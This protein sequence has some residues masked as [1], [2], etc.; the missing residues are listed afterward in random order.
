MRWPSK[1]YPSQ[2]HYVQPSACRRSDLKLRVAY[3]IIQSYGIK[4][5]FVSALTFP[6]SH[7]LRFFFLSK[8]AYCDNPITMDPREAR[9]TGY[10]TFSSTLEI[11]P[12]T[13]GPPRLDPYHKILSRFYEPLVLLRL[14]GQSRGNHQPK[15]HDVNA[16]QAVR[17]DFLRNLSYICDFEKGGDTCTA[18][19]LA[20]LGAC[21]RLYVA[22][23]KGQAKIAEFLKDVLGLLRDLNEVPGSELPQKEAEFVKFCV[24]FAERRIRKEKSHLFRAADACSR[25]L[26]H[27]ATTEGVHRQ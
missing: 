10:S 15:P 21:Y 25:K 16:V 23:D 13:V 5:T 2:I 17:R 9:S 7:V 18:I 26:S 12:K 6:F 19:G 4:T 11:K 8:T 24:D 3:V 20:D 27:S 14:L 22:S 1:K